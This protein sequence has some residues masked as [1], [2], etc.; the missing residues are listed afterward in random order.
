MAAGVKRPNQST[1][2]AWRTDDVG[3]DG[4][5]VYETKLIVDTC[6]VIKENREECR[7][8]LWPT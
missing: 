4:E 6:G 1:L 2:F 8:W 7:F 3:R 5:T